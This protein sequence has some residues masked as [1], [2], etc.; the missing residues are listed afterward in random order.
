MTKIQ[1]KNRFY[2]IVFF[3]CQLHFKLLYVF[4]QDTV[5]SHIGTTDK[6]YVEDCTRNCN[7]KYLRRTGWDVK[8]SLL[9]D[10]GYVNQE[11]NLRQV[12]FW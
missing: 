7:T 12:I 8:N 2:L 11:I 1:K 9:I 5:F 4:Y 3:N 6:V 10:G